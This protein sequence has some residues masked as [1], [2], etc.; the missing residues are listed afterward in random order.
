MSKAEMTNIP[1]NAADAVDGIVAEGGK[2][3]AR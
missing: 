1:A 2:T 3:L